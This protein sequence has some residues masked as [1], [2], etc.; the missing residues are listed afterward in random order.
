MLQLTL[1]A[2]FE[3]RKRVMADKAFANAH[4]VAVVKSDRVL[5]G[6]AEGPRNSHAGQTVGSFRP[7]TLFVL[8][9]RRIGCFRPSPAHT[10]T[11][12]PTRGRRCRARRTPTTCVETTPE[13]T[14]WRRAQGGDE[15]R[16]DYNCTV[17]LAQIR[18]VGI[19]DADNSATVPARFM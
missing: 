14:V 8:E 1:G 18:R 15:T 16:T 7:P 17:D 13:R 19:G 11:L 9:P 2:S 3:T 6:Q 10:K 12:S 4:R 5:A